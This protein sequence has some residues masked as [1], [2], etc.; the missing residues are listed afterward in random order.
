MYIKFVPWSEDEQKIKDESSSYF[1]QLIPENSII[2]L[3]IRDNEKNSI[4][5]NESCPFNLNCDYFKNESNI[6]TTHYYNASYIRDIFN[7][8]SENLEKNDNEIINFTNNTYITKNNKSFVGPKEEGGEIKPLRNKNIYNYTKFF[9]KRNVNFSLP[10]VYISINLFHP[11]LRPMNSNKNESKCYYFKILEFFSAIKRKIEEILADAIRAG[12]EITIG[13][14]LEYLSIDTFCYEDVAFKIMEKIK[15]IIF[16]TEWNSTDFKINNI[17]YKNIIFDDLN[18]EKYYISDIS[19]NYFYCELK[20]S[21]FNSYEFFPD[22]FDYQTCIKDLDSEL[23]N[24]RTFIIN[25]YIYGYYK[26]KEAQKIADLFDTNYTIDNLQELL[27]NVNNSEIGYISPDNFINW[28]KEIKKLNESYQKNISVKVYNKSDYDSNCYNFGI[29]FIKFNESEL[30]ILLFNSLLNKV[31]YGENLYLIYNFKYG[32]IFLQ[33]IFY[34]SNIHSQIPNEKLL[35]D[36]WKKILDK[37]YQF[38]ERVD[39]IGNRYYYVKKNFLSTLYVMQ[40]SLKQ[41]A[42]TEIE[43]MLYNGTVLD[44]VKLSDDYNKKYKGKKTRKSELNETIEFY[45]NITNRIRIDFKTLDK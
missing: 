32:D 28:S 34:D 44:T 12:N 45:S 30:D 4:T 27:Y 37:L 25:G 22:E 19:R 17:I 7:F 14:Y 24:L 39:N 5:C 15:K 31:D 40:T 9:F 23:E 20:N 35:K 3:G 8:S 2:T 10:K 18:Y 11:Y 21:L 43:G 1:R 6:V 13:K 41:R 16:D 26:E 29:S 36:S 38:N 42:I 33:F